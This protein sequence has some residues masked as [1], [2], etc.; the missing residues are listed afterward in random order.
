MTPG[1]ASTYLIMLGALLRFI[2]RDN[3]IYLKLPRFFLRDFEKFIESEPSQQ[4]NNRK[5]EKKDIKAKSGRAVSAYLACIRAIHN[6]AKE[7]FNDEDRGIIR[8]PFSP[9]KK[10]KIKSQPKTRKR[11]L[12]PETMQAIIDL[13]TRI[14]RYPGLTWLKIVLYYLLAS[15]E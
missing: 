11:G 6:K 3:L 9:F 7:E 2:K 14:K 1:T 10:Y 15:S 5:I 8:I 12:T 13:P 4:G